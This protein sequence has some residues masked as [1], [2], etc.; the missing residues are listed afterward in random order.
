MADIVGI[1]A[2]VFDFLVMTDAF[3]AEDTKYRAKAS[4]IQG[5]GPCATALVAAAKL[6]ASAEYFGVLGTDL[7]GGYMLEEFRRYGVSTGSIRMVDGFSSAN[8]VVILN[9]LKGTRTCVFSPGTLPPATE[10]DVPMEKLAKAKY[11]HL[12]GNQ[13]GAA[14]YAAKKARKLGVKV[15]LDAGF[16]YPGIEDILPLTDILIPSEEFV[17]KWSGNSTVEAGAKKLYRQY[18]PEIFAVTQ[19]PRGGF[20]FNGE[21]FTPY[22]PFPAEIIDTNG[23][24]DTFHGAFL[25]GLVR[26]MDAGEA[27]RFAS[28]VAALKCSHFGAREGIP[29]YDEV[30]KAIQ[31][32]QT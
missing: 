29:P 5:G 19:G 27:A 18:K 32:I 24:G 23:A 9:T 6:G 16:P 26:G 1:G 22:D 17:V 28:A 7:Y 2:S 12:D 14:I 10:E 31:S 11:L 20:F 15:S 30:M 13:L 8:S 25:A 3:P 4:K 21:T